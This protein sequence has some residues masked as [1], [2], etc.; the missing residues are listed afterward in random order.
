MSHLFVTT[1]LEKSY[2]INFNMIGLDGKPEVKG[3][4]T[5]LKE[6]LIYRLAT[7]KGVCTIDLKK[8]WIESM[9]LK[10]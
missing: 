4:L 2:R 9:C 3:L 8:Y 1:D 7:V 10:A 6:W 5:I